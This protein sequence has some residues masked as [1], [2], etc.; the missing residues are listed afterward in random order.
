MDNK[1]IIAI[2]AVAVIVVAGVAAVVVLNNNNGG[3]SSDEGITCQM[4]VYGNANQDDY[5]NSSDITTLESIIS[6]GNWDKNKTPLADANQDGKVDSNDVDLVNK[7]LAGESATMYYMDWNNE[8]SSISYPLTNVLGDTYGI[9]TEFSTGLDMAIILGIEGYFT[10]MA[11]G[12]IGPSSLDTTMYPMASSLTEVAIKSPG[13]EAMYAD[14]VRV[15]MGDP[16]WL[17]GYA[18]D[19]EAL[20][21]TVIKLPENRVINGVD[22]A[23]TLVTLGA[24]FNLQDKTADYLTFQAKC[25][26]AIDKVSVSD[27]LSYVIPYWAPGY[28]EIYVDGHGTGS[29]V[30]ADVTTLEY[31]PVT[32]KMSTTAIDGFDKVDAESI[33]ALNPDMFMVAMFGYTSN[34]DYTVAQ[35]Q[36]AFIDFV[37]LGFQSTDAVKNERM[38][39]MPFENCEL[40]GTASILVLGSMMYPD[41]IDEDEAWSLMYE[42]YSTFTNWDGSSVDDLKA[43]KFAPLSYT[44]LTA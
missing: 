39:A 36:Q 27:K 5:L 6:S 16:K 37:N 18:S 41:A 19:A 26:A 34:K 24:M 8:V 1:I 42:Y 21:F 33:A 3:S 44:E 30:T 43:S 25:V 7:F 4:R 23:D 28:T 40:A 29:M 38:F 15:L 35:T 32:S 11:N 14:N 13:L 20:G 22:S 9:Y 10:Y 31:L 12:D 17:G 2:A